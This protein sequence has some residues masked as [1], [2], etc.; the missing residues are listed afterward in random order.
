MAA[1]GK[2]IENAKSAAGNLPN[3]CIIKRVARLPLTYGATK[4]SHMKYDLVVASYILYEITNAQERRRIIHQLWRSC[5]G[6][7]V[8]I[9][10]GTPGGAANIQVQTRL[11]S[12]CNTLCF[13]GS[14]DDAVRV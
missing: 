14:S 4:H 8:F 6:L 9:E 2:E 12:Q 5:G 13:V 3:K 11:I 1:L 10:P 7:I